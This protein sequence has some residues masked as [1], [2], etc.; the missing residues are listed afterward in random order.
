MGDSEMEKERARE[1]EKQKRNG[2]RAAPKTAQRWQSTRMNECSI[3]EWE[4]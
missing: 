4:T 1:R 3:T 2:E